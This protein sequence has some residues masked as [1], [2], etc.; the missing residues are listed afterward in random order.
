MEN[1]WFSLPAFYHFPAQKLCFLTK[2]SVG[3][4]S[5][6]FLCHDFSLL[7]VVRSISMWHVTRFSFHS[8]IAPDLIRFVQELAFIPRWIFGWGRFWFG[9]LPLASRQYWLKLQCFISVLVHAAKALSTSVFKCEFLLVPF[10]Y[11]LELPDKRLEFLSL[12][13]WNACEVVR[14]FVRP[15]LACQSL[16]HVLLASCR[17]FTLINSL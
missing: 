7:V 15:I 14:S 12:F 9:L 4:P 10:R 11:C 3:E 2:L 1:S 17:V 6:F 16:A 5:W 8:V 13:L